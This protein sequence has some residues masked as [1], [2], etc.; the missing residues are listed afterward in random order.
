MLPQ[1]VKKAKVSILKIILFESILSG[2]YLI[3]SFTILEICSFRW[4]ICLFSVTRFASSLRGDFCLYEDNVSF[5]AKRF[6]CSHFPMEGDSDTGLV[7]VLFQA[8]R[9]FFVGGLLFLQ[10][11]TIVIL[12]KYSEFYEWGRVRSLP[13]LVSWLELWR[14]KGCFAEKG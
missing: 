8:E 11:M 6:V 3:G 9:F 12:R 4:E 10:K 1:L 14:L 13:I 7:R 2:S 5:S